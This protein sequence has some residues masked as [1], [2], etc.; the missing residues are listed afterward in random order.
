MS[1]ATTFLPHVTNRLVLRHFAAADL[2]R[3]LAYRR[4]PEV[5]RYQGW[6]TLSRDEAIR[7]IEGNAQTD[8]L[9]PGDWLQIAIAEKQTNLLVGDIGIHLLA[10]DPTALEIG[11]TLA[12]REQGKGYGYEAANALIKR[13]FNEAPI[14][15]IIGITDER[16]V[17]SSSMTMPAGE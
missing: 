6:S 8:L 16:N 17:P 15:R 4:D 13:L 9:L 5:A 1:L 2:E 12:R 14:K 11:F 7:F 10:G 3:L